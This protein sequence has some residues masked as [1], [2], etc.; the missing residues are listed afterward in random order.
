VAVGIDSIDADEL[1][2]QANTEPK[3]I[4]GNV[5]RLDGDGWRKFRSKGGEHVHDVTSFAGAVYAV[6]SGADTRLEFGA[7]RSFAT[8]G[9][10]RTGATFETV[11]RIQHPTPGQGDSLGDAVA[12]AKARSCSATRATRY[13]HGFGGE[14]RFRRP[15]RDELV[16]ARPLYALFPDGVLALP[17]GTAIVFGVDVDQPSITRRATFPRTARSRCSLRWL[18]A[19]CSTPTFPLR[20][21]CSTSRSQ[22][23]LRRRASRE[24]SRV[25][26]ADAAT[27]DATSVV[28]SDRPTSARLHRVLAGRAVLGH[29]RRSSAARRWHRVTM[30]VV[31]IVELATSADA[32]AAALTAELGGTPYEHRLRLVGGSPAIALRTPERELALRTLAGLRARGHGAVACDEAAIVPSERMLPCATSVWSRTRCSR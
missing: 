23:A 7:A 15:E 14:R 25:L 1:R 3:A 12:H 21:S 8:S 27:P 22:A 13:Q 9:A 17:D 30:Y 6:S 11:T 20:P 28:S 29:E 24:L 18:A 2:T 32:E 16:A 4:E 19:P 31:A 26:V 5:Y 10:A